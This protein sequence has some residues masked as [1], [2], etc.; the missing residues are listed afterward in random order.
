MPKRRLPLR[1]RSTPI[2]TLQSL[3]T[4]HV[5]DQSGSL[6]T[7]D[8]LSPWRQD[9][10]FILTH[11]RPTT[12]SFFACFQSL[13]YIHNESVNIYSHLVGAVLFFFISMSLYAFER[14]SAAAGDVLAF[15]FFF[16]GAV[17]CLSISAMFHMVS[18]HSPEV[19]EKNL[20]RRIGLVKFD[21]ANR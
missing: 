18:S 1:T 17:A 3:P 10:H 20:V 15:S 19:H 5:V 8:Q 4:A 12:K 7:F 9:N 2:S 16:L 13:F 6:L 11:Y 14:R 21:F